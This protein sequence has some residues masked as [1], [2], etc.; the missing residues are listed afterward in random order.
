MSRAARTVPAGTGTAPSTA[1]RAPAALRESR[2]PAI[3]RAAMELF[4]EKGYPATTM[5]DIG[6]AVDLRGPSLYK[7]VSSKQELLAE[8]MTTTMSRLRAEQR[9]AVAS[10]DDVREQLRRVVEAHVRYHARHR[11][12]AFLGNHELRSLDEGNRTV[13]LAQRKEYERCVRGLVERGVAEGRF[14]VR[15]V[16]LAVFA[17][18]D[19][20]TGLAVWFREGGEF[21]VDEVAY[22]YGDMAMVLVGAVA[23]P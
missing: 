18:L 3:L 21:S 22:R 1:S 17:L 9:A 8:I 6:R 7:H 10:T 12:E 16:K 2:R 11:V 5:E 23:G 4:A 14:T 20:G 13:L 15:S 19:M